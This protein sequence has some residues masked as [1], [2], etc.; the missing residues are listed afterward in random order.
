MCPPAPPEPATFTSWRPEDA[1]VPAAHEAA[2]GASTDP[3]P[4]D[5]R[6]RVRGA[7]LPETGPARRPDDD[8]PR[9]SAEQVRS[10]LSRFRAGVDRGR[11][12]ESGQPNPADEGDRS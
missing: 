6:R 8:E 3:D 10:Q 2:S 4:G 9:R 7:Q 1:D 5:L 11:R 12:E